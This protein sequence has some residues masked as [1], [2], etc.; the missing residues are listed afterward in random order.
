VNPDETIKNEVIR[1]DG[2]KAI[3]T[4]KVLAVQKPVR[5]GPQDTE[6]DSTP[7]TVDDI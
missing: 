4:R 7:E 6:N 3:V 1:A 5:S 2:S